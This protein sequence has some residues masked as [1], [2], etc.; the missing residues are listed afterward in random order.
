VRIEAD[1]IVGDLVERARSTDIEAQLLAAIYTHLCVYQHVSHP[2]EPCSLAPFA[3]YAGSVHGRVNH[4]DTACMRLM[5]RCRIRA[6]LPFV[7]LI[8]Q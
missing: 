8:N 4:L 6:P 5:M 7:T 2:E 1:Q 3:K